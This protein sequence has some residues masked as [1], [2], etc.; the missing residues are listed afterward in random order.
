MRPEYRSG[1]AGAHPGLPVAAGLPGFEENSLTVIRSAAP[2]HLGAVGRIL[3]LPVTVA[4][5]L[6]ACSNNGNRGVTGNVGVGTGVVLSTPGSATQLQVATTIVVTASV[7]ADVNNAG[8]I[9]SMTGSAVALGATLEDQTATTVTF[10]APTT[11]TGAVDATITATSVV[12]PTSVA[13]VT[14]IVLGTPV[15]NP[16]QL[17]PGNVNVP[18]S[19]SITVAGGEPDFTWALKTGSNPVPPG[20][21]LDGTTSSVDA[22]SGTPIS[23][24]T[25]TFT[26][27][28]TD[29]LG[30]VVSQDVTMVVLP[31]ETCLLIGHF[32]YVFSGFRGGGPATDAGSIT[33]DSSGNITGEHDYKDGHRTTTHELLTSGNCINRQTNSG[34]ITLTG[35]SGSLLYNFAVTPPTSPDDPTTI[36]S[37]R[38]QLVGSGSDS[39]SGQ[40]ARVDTAAL[41]AAPPTGNFA[42][43][44]LTVANQE[45]VT[46]HTGSVGRLTTDATGTISAGLTDSNAIP[47]LSAATLSGALSAPDSNG[48]GTATFTAGSITSNLV[49]YIVNAAKI[50]L[51]DMNASVGSPRSTGLLTAQTGDVAGG[52][53]DAGALAASPSIL[54][55]WGA[56]G[57]GIDP[58]SVMSLGRLSNGDAATGTLDAVLDTSDEDIDTAGV[59]YSAQPYTVDSSGRGTLSLS[60]AG[61]P[62]RSFVFYLDGIANGYVIEPGSPSGNAGLLEAQYTP[63]QGI[64]PDTLPGLF[65]GGTQYVQTPGPIILASQMSLS[66]GGISSNYTSGQ[67]GVD[68][69]TGRGFGSLTESGIS[70]TDAALYIVSPTKID[71]M[72]FGTFRVD[73]TILWLIGQ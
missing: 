57:S 55:I 3:L 73:G 53:F 14:L 25:Y 41:S 63:T 2:W 65:V 24:G 51:E 71:V 47:A 60:V 62:T 22:L 23:A 8:V 35:P 26:V 20:M 61:A 32:A 64:Y 19:A 58:I 37:A 70:S 27:Q 48:R 28:A 38:L 11:A 59:L 9:W 15:M 49:Y 43:G 69:A 34:Q 46:V 29:S 50:Y 18:Y 67:F 12:N 13:S 40:L 45:P 5:A 42:F 66:F 10:A 31:E 21:I 54:S 56:F 4:L 44:L 16:V 30:R 1:G 68:P 33:I 7:T 52:A 17:F 6:V 72:T 36:N 39:G